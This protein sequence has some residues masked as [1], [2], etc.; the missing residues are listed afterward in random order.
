MISNNDSILINNLERFY[1]E[2]V[3]HKKNTPDKLKRQNPI[4]LISAEYATL[5]ADFGGST[6]LVDNYD[7]VFSTWLLKSYLSCVS[8]FIRQYGGKIIAFEGDG[9]MGIFSGPDK[10]CNAVLCG[11]KIQWA[12]INIIQPKID[13]YFP[14][15][16]YHMHQVVG[17]D[18]SELIPINTEIG[19]IY[20]ILWIGRSANYSANLTRIDNPAYST[21]ITENV[22]SK[23]PKEL[24]RHGNDTIWEQMQ[25]HVLNIKVFRSNKTISLAK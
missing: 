4:N 7:L 2:V 11:F 15:Y 9:L 21:Y 13:Y 6:E 16:E 12:V 18:A 20:D 22:Y 17:I 14:K 19:D 5:F 1:R 25:E 3:G 10:E 23:L 8:L 24:Q